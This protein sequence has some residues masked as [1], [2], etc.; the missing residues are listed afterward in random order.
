[1]DS[2]DFH[3]IDAKQICK[4]HGMA[5]HGRCLGMCA[6][7]RTGFICAQASLLTFAPSTCSNMVSVALP[8]LSSSNGP[9]SPNEISVRARLG[10]IA[11]C[12]SNK[13]QEQLEFVPVNV[14]VAAFIRAS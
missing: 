4:K 12:M 10:P 14:L 7:A 2:D 9:L 6:N 11:T 3:E 8:L 5:W 13:R 1:M